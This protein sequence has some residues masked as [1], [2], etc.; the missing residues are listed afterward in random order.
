MNYEEYRK[1]VTG[2]AERCAACSFTQYRDPGFQAIS[3]ADP[4]EVIPWMVKDLAN[5]YGET[6]CFKVSV[7][8]LMMLLASKAVDRPIIPENQRGRVEYIRQAWLKWGADHG[9][10]VTQDEPLAAGVY[11]PRKWDFWIAD[12]ALC[13]GDKETRKSHTQIGF[14]IVFLIGWGVYW[15][16]KH[17]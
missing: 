3:D 2:Y 17:L 6:R 13:W 8:M 10:D 9:Y 11:V 16:V 1:H 7:H 4:Q 12:Y 15:V 5:A 14:A